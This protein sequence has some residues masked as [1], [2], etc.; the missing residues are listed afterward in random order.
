MKKAFDGYQTRALYHPFQQSA[1]PAGF[2]VL[3]FGLNR[4]LQNLFHR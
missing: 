3:P 1:A 2:S 4:T